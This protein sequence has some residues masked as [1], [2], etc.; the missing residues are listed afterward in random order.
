MARKK[1]RSL[2]SKLGSWKDQASLSRTA[3]QSAIPQTEKPASA[4]KPASPATRENYLVSRSL[5][6]RLADAAQKHNMK[7]NE[8]VGYLLTWSLDQLDAGKVEMP[9]G[10][11]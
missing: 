1:K 6:E 2:E 10:N 9:Q 7:Q 11:A 3:P 4:S 5:I 8:V